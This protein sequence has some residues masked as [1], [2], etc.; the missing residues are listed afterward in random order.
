MPITQCPEC[1]K[2]YKVPTDQASSI[3]GRTA[4][5]KRC[6]ARFVV[7]L[8]SPTDSEK[9]LIDQEERDKAERRRRR[10]TKA[11][12]RSEYIDTV[13]SGF[14]ALH[15]R[16]SEIDRTPSSSE[17]EIRRWTIDA[18]RSCLGYDDSDIC[19]ES[20][21]HDRK[22]D[23][24]IS[25]SEGKPLIVVE[26]KNIR[27]PL[28]QRVVDQ[29]ASYTFG[30]S[31]PYAVITNGAVWR[32][33]KAGKDHNHNNAL[34][35]V[36]DV[37]LLDDDGVSDDDAELLYLLSKRSMSSGD[38]ESHC[39]QA[40]SMHTLRLVEA[41]LDEGVVAKVRRAL[42]TRYKDETG[43]NVDIDLDYLKDKLEEF[44]M[45]GEL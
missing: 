36:F 29:A 35:E 3:V 15:N 11:E 22:I 23:I 2:R 19:T 20:K 27:R 1:G 39:H 25:D 9:A 7:Q 45:P 24:L 44:V 42:I 10:R 13:A 32:F 26:T 30:V 17:E 43:V 33:F 28:N 38:T 34:I 5:C 37:A 41:L 6:R 21:V 12:I 8:I 40:A 18:L 4:T 31:A 16:L 14:R